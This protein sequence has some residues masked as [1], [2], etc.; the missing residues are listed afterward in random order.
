MLLPALASP[1]DILNRLRAMLIRLWVTLNTMIMVPRC[2]AVIVVAGWFH[3]AFVV[4]S[5][6]LSFV[7]TLFQSFVSPAGNMDV[8]TGMDIQDLS[9][10]FDNTCILDEDLELK[11]KML[12]KTTFS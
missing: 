3:Q 2:V 9:N 7:F 1:I 11:Q 10:D 6:T 12:R 4:H 8:L 5:F